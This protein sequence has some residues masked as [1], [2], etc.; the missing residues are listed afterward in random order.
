MTTG[1]LFGVGVRLVGLATVLLNLPMLFGLSYP[2]AFQLVAAVILIARPNLFVAA[3]YPKDAKRV[4]DSPD[5]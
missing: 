5:Y 2:G 4:Q 3:C 1:E